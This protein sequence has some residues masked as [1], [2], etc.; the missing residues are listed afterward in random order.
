MFTDRITKDQN[1]KAY[2][3]SSSLSVAISIIAIFFVEKKQCSES[4]DWVLLKQR[5]FSSYRGSNPTAKEINTWQQKQKS[6]Q[7]EPKHLA[8]KISCQEKKK[9]RGGQVNIF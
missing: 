1:N 8:R 4:R 6:G 7:K 2:H 3:L 9:S 5:P